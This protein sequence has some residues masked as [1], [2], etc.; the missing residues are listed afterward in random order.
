MKYYGNLIIYLTLFISAGCSS[1]V[2]FKEKKIILKNDETV[3]IKEIDLTITNNGCGRKWISEDK[4]PSYER[5]YCDLEIKKGDKTITAGGD[6]EPVFIGNIQIIVEKMN[7]WGREEDSIP[8]RGCRVW[9]K[10]L[11]GR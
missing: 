1:Q 8:P 4:K 11:E 9:V 5:P 3:R 2:A 6:F 7:P 10:L